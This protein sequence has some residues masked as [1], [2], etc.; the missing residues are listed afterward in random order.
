M[1][2]LKQNFAESLYQVVLTYHFS[3]NCVVKDPSGNE[4]NGFQLA[5]YEPVNN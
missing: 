2:P 3:E 1:V 4:E 5:G